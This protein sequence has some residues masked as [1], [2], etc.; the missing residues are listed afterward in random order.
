MFNKFKCPDKIK[1]L[2]YILIPY[3]N[4]LSKIRSQ[5]KRKEAVKTTRMNRDR[6]RQSGKVMAEK[7]KQPES[8]GKKKKRRIETK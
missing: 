7:E 5:S 4:Q 3:H 2:K 1:Y 6:G 8:C